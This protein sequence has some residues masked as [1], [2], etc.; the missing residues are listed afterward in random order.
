MMLPVSQERERKGT[1]WGGL[2]EGWGASSWGPR[3]VA[4]SG[5]KWLLRAFVTL[6]ILPSRLQF[7]FGGSGGQK[8]PTAMAQEAQAQAYLQ[9]ARVSPA[10]PLPTFTG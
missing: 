1:S 4:G 5:R 9:Q 10:S 2:Q 6:L 3:S 7:R 8:G